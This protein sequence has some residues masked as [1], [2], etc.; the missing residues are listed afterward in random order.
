MKKTSPGCGRCVSYLCDMNKKKPI[1]PQRLD[2]KTVYESQWINLY[3]DKVL[4]P[5]GKIIDKY[6]FLDYQKKG[7]VVLLINSKKE[8]CFIKSL[9]YTKQKIEWELPAGS[10]EKRETALQ[11]AKREVLEETGYKTKSLKLLYKFN[12]S[13]GMSNQTIHAVLGFTSNDQHIPFETDEVAKIHWLS[14]REVTKC[15]FI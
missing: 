13:T 5:S 9:R 12:P 11:A 7:V 14:L 3:T 4:M 6:H 2:R 8:V 10:I 1:L 15:C